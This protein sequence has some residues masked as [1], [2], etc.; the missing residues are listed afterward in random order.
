MR[1]VLLEGAGEIEARSVIVAT[2][3]S[4]RRLEAEGLDALTGRGAYYGANASDAAQ[5]DG[6]EVYVVGAANSAG[7]AALN[8][9]RFAKRVVL[10]VRGATWTTHVAATSS[11]GSTPTRR[12]TCGS[13]PRSRRP[14]ATATS[15]G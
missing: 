13:A 5:F 9:A 1:A 6:D 3:V 4:Y 10:V 8:L 2:G 15:S 11:T 12:S 7:Q 14:A